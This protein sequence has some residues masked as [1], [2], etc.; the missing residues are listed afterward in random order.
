MGRTGGTNMKKLMTLVLAVCMLL[1]A[2]TAFA[3]PLQ[4][5][6]APE[7]V[8]K[9]IGNTMVYAISYDEAGAAVAL[10]E[11]SMITLI[12]ISARAKD[13]AVMDAAAKSEEVFAAQNYVVC[14][15]FFM[16]IEGAHMIEATF[17]LQDWQKVSL[18]FVT[19]DGINWT[20]AELIVNA[21]DTVTVKTVPGVVALVA[22]F[23]AGAAD[24]PKTNETLDHSSF[25]PSVA[26]KPAP[27]VIAAEIVDAEGAVVKTVIPGVQLVVTPVSAMY[28][29]KD[30]VVFDSL[31]RS[32]NEILAAKSL[33]DLGLDGDMIVRDLF[34]VTLYGETLEA[35]YT[36]KA[37]F[38][39]DVPAAVAVNGEN[40]WA[41]VD[42]ENIV[43]NGNGTVTV[44]LSELGT[45]AFL[46]ETA[47]NVV[48]SPA[49]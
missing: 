10:T 40:G 37:T 18:A 2:T 31:S 21:D 32:Y 33:A 5:G 36:L 3:E 45:V 1:A 7:L 22:D 15:K 34:E 48:T 43:D 25:T 4:D 29:T 12:D 16:N 26:A 17:A 27:T 14:E 44:A 20:K 11:K 42:A 49:T 6:K 38:E 28:Y 35:G 23:G 19:V 8:A 24:A 47:Q 9:E 30:I 41:Y 46:V 39:A 13:D